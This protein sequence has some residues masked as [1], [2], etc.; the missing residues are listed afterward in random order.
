MRRP[1]SSAPNW[2]RRNGRPLELRP[3]PVDRGGP[4]APPPCVANQRRGRTWLSRGDGASAPDAVAAVGEADMESTGPRGGTGPERGPEVCPA[5]C[6][7]ARRDPR[8][9]EPQRRRR[10]RRGRR[11][12]ARPASRWTPPA[13]PEPSPPAPTSRRTHNRPGGAARRVGRRV[14]AWPTSPARTRP[15]RRQ[16]AWG[17]PGAEDLHGAREAPVAPRHSRRH[18]PARAARPAAPHPARHRA[19]LRRRQGARRFRRRRSGSVV[20]PISTGSLV[21]LSLR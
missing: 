18:Q 9:P 20:H 4:R 6:R 8:A 11:G 5:D 10:G 13:G 17:P 12:R 1:A 3:A 15:R 7:R 14:N 2:A 21:S 19:A 16:T